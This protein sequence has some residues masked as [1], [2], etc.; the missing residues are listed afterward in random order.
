MA[1]QAKDR[2]P[3]N[4]ENQKTRSERRLEEIKGVLYQ[5]DLFYVQE[6]VRNTLI[7]QHHDNPLAEHFGIKKSQKLII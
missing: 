4:S 7:N 2:R 3:R 6:L 1:T 5:K